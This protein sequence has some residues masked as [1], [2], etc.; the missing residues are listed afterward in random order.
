MPGGLSPDRELVRNLSQVRGTWTVLHEERAFRVV[1][2]EKRIEGSVIWV[3]NDRGFLWEPAD[4]LPSA[5]AF[6]ASE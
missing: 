6:L 3:V 5:L 1:E 4:S 2:F